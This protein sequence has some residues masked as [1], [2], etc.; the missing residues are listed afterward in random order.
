MTSVVAWWEY[1]LCAYLLTVGVRALRSHSVL[2]INLLIFPS[3]ITLWAAYDL[4]KNEPTLMEG[5]IWILAVGLGCTV[6]WLFLNRLRVQVDT[7]KR[8]LFIEGSV[9]TLL[10][11]T[12]FILTQWFLTSAHP[13]MTVIQLSGFFTGIFVGRGLCFLTKYMLHS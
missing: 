10:L 7:T 11:T 12:L 3:V 13:S 4:F 5:S 2:L 8:S 9:V 1:V 6:G